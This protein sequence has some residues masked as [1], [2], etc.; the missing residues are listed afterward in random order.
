M[1][2]MEV[3]PMAAEATTAQPLE[4]GWLP[5]TPAGDTLLHDYV[6]H[7]AERIVAL[8]ELHGGRVL[9]RPDVVAAD[10]GRPAGLANC[11][12]LLQPPVGDLGV[13]ADLED[14]YAGQGH[15][16]V[17]LWSPWPTPDL[18]AR[19]WV[20]EGHPPLLVRPPDGPLPP[21][22]PL[23]RVHRVSSDDELELACR[24]LV[25]GFPLRELQ[26]YRPGAL[27]AARLWRDPRW[28]VWFATLDGQPVSAAVL[29]VARGMAQLHLAATLPHARGRGAWQALVRAR[30]QAAHGLL[31][32]GV[33]SDHS[34]PGIARLGYLPITR[35][36]LWHRTR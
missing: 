1:T 6:V 19:G 4:T 33:F 29:F 27:F 22:V 36:T 10:L 23:T 12:M 5:S 16:T 30:L 3:R 14:W 24:V 32:A 21:A 2:E 25:D 9:R 17:L 34:R 7:D 26:P 35:F 13:V 20:L 31:S 18:H 11:A 8:A 15:G 28:Q